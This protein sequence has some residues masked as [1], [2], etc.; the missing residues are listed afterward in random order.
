[1]NK[2]FYCLASI[3]LFVPALAFSI[4]VD[5]HYC[6]NFT[7]VISATNQCP[8]AVG[9]YRATQSLDRHIERFVSTVGGDRFIYDGSVA[10][11]SNSEL[12]RLNAWGMFVAKDNHPI[13]F[14]E[15]IAK[16]PRRDTDKY[17]PAMQGWIA[18]PTLHCKMQYVTSHACPK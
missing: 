15:S 14:L 7:K 16:E 12:I 2:C 9:G 5:E 4:D 1:M 11:P 10:L 8:Y 3:V 13:K 18:I 6:V 17:D